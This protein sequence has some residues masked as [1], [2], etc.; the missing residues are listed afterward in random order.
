MASQDYVPD[1]TFAS[2]AA[3]LKDLM[4][5]T[6]DVFGRIEG[7]VSSSQYRLSALNDRISV[8]R[9]RITR[10]GQSTKAVT[11][12][13]ATKYPA[14]EVARY[15]NYV[16]LHAGAAFPALGEAHQSDPL[17]AEQAAASVFP[18]TSQRGVNQMA[19]RARAGGREGG[20]GRVRPEEHGHASPLLPPPPPPPTLLPL[21]PTTWW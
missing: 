18:P 8:I 5:V 20:K 16:C 21:S 19:V 6:D 17:L 2:I 15:S 13:S 3:A 12:Y 10:I 1:D 9:D 14:V 4:R 11:I 7:Q